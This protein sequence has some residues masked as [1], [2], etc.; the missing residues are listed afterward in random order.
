MDVVLFFWWNNHQWNKDHIFKLTLPYKLPW[1]TVSYLFIL[2]DSAYLVY[3]VI[4]LGF[5]Y[6][7]HKGSTSWILKRIVI[8]LLL[9]LWYKRK[10]NRSQDRKFFEKPTKIL[11]A[12]YLMSWLSIAGTSHFL[13]YLN[14]TK[15]QLIF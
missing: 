7:A 5:T 8:E 4:P 10:N 12:V 11:A 14:E 1:C 2:L 13:K 3:A 6:Q 15:L 9:F